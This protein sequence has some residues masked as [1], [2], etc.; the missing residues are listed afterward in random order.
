MHII[1]TYFAFDQSAVT[2][3]PSFSQYRLNGHNSMKT[4][5]NKFQYTTIRQNNSKRVN[6]QLIRLAYCMLRQ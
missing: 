4:L 5:Y 6:G 3:W 1:V 2:M